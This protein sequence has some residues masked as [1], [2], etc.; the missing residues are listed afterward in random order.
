[1][2]SNGIFVQGAYPTHRVLVSLAG[3]T[4]HPYFETRASRLHLKVLVLLINLCPSKTPA[5]VRVG[6]L[7]PRGS[8]GCSTVGPDCRL[9]GRSHRAGL[10]QATGEHHHRHRHRHRHRH[11]GRNIFQI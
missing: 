11:V 3:K 6:P 2:S 10:R 9:Q 7:C 5:Q 1:M 8:R 4:F